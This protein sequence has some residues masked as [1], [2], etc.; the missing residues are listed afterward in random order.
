MTFHRT[1]ELTSVICEALQACALTF[2]RGQWVAMNGAKGRFISNGGGTITVVWRY[3]AEPF[4]EYN[5]RFK[6]ACLINQPVSRPAR[7]LPADT[8]TPS[9]K[10]LQQQGAFLFESFTCT[11]FDEPSINDDSEQYI[12]RATT[13]Q[14]GY[15]LLMQCRS[16]LLLQSEVTGRKSIVIRDSAKARSLLIYPSHTRYSGYPTGWGSVCH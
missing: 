1:V 4:R 2:N 11:D 7:S 16:A 9:P 8:A 6:R 10:F 5:L 15:R 14:E 3:K 12:A 13:W